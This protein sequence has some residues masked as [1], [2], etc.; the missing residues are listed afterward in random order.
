MRGNACGGEERVILGRGRTGGIG[1]KEVKGRR[2]RKIVGR[3]KM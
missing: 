3:K 2:K 1:D